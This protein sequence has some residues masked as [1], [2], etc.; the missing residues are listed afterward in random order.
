MDVLEGK[1]QTIWQHIDTALSRAGQRAADEMTR[2]K[3]R[4]A[5]AAA[6]KLARQVASDS[7][8]K[9]YADLWEDRQYRQSEPARDEAPVASSVSF[10]EGMAVE[11]TVFGPGVVLAAATTDGD[12]LITVDF[13]TAGRKTLAASLVGDK[14]L[15]R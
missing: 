12:T 7:D 13:V 2:Q 10:S 15:P 1:A 11:H 8:L 14:L 5:R 6:A 3:V 9:L 4:E